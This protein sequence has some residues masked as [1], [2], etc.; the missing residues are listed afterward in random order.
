[1]M[2]PPPP[3]PS[4]GLVSM[5]TRTQVRYLIH[6]ISLIHKF[7]DNPCDFKGYI[8]VE[9]LLLIQ[10]FPHSHHPL[11]QT[12]IAIPTL[13]YKQLRS[14]S[15]STFF[16]TNPNKPNQTFKMHASAAVLAFVAVA[17]AAQTPVAPVATPIATPG[18]R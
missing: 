4:G 12:T 15:L 17:A 16:S 10:S 3:S 7:T 5:Y 8:G 11:Q 1:M 14:T 2:Q 18:A 13:V 9:A 6:C